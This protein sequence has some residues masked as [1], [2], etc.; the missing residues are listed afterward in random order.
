MYMLLYVPSMM[1]LEKLRA[2]SC[3]LAVNHGG[4]LEAG[5]AHLAWFG[6]GACCR[7]RQLIAQEC[8]RGEEAQTT[9]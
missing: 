7:A 6:A 1:Q 5:N 2:G 3:A 8:S 4:I 9:R